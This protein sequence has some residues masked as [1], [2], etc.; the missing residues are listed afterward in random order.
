MSSESK[1]PKHDKRKKLQKHPRNADYFC[2]FEQIKENG[3]DGGG[4]G[5]GNWQTALLVRPFLFSFAG[6]CP[7]SHN[8][9]VAR[10]VLRLGVLDSLGRLLHVVLVPKRRQERTR[11]REKHATP[12]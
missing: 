3:S 2:S 1:K 7:Y 8:I 4:G 10:R 9:L 6:S 11:N 5:G 12:H